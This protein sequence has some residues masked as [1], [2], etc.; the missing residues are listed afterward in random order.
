MA[1]AARKLET[2]AEIDLMEN[3]VYM[4][5]EGKLVKAPSPHSGHGTLTVHF[6]GGKPCHGDLSEKFQV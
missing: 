1:D 2:M 6:Q 5:K 3:A 4:V